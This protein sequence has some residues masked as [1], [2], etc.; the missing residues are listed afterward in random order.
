MI[1][2]SICCHMALSSR[3]FLQYMQMGMMPSRCGLELTLLGLR[4]WVS[5]LA[6]SRRRGAEAVERDGFENRCPVSLVLENAGHRSDVFTPDCKAS[7]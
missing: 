5:L 3:I 1:Y 6:A 4:E 2:C 7:Q